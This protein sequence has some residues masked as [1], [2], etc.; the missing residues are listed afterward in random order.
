MTSLKN[1][2][3][4]KSI[5]TMFVLF[6]KFSQIASRDFRFLCGVLEEKKLNLEKKM[7]HLKP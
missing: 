4:R 3:S 1:G 5:L 7:F 6:Y 2:D